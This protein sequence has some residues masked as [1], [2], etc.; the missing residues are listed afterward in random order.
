MRSS[1][2]EIRCSRVVDEIQLRLLMRSILGGG[3]DLI[4]CGWDLAKFSMSSRQYCGWDLAEWLGAWLSMPRSRDSHGFNPRIIQHCGM[5]GE[6]D[7]TMLPTLFVALITILPFPRFLRPMGTIFHMKNISTEHSFLNSRICFMYGTV[8]IYGAYLWIFT[9]WE[10]KNFSVKLFNCY[11]LPSI[12]LVETSL[13][14]IIFVPYFGF[15]VK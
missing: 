7:E 5:R 6:A 2:L 13:R 14:K 3:R 4:N 1:R 8:Y 10:H 11:C 15:T 12:Y 9:L